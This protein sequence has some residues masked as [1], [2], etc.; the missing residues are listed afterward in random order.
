MPAELAHV[1]VKTCSVVAYTDSSSRF[2]FKLNCK[3]D[4]KI[5]VKYLSR[6]N[7]AI[8]EFECMITAAI[9]SAPTHLTILPLLFIACHRPIFTRGACPFQYWIKNLKT[10]DS[11]SICVSFLAC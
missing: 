6:D 11:M 7:K 1:F 9:N 5:A 4:E 3:E 8:V 10:R 2:W